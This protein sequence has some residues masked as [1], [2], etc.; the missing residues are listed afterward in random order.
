MSFSKRGSTARAAV[1]GLGLTLVAPAIGAAEDESTEEAPT[2]QVAAAESA[3]EGPVY[4]PPARERPRRRIGGGVRGPE[5]QWPHVYALVPTHT[6]HTSA[7][8]PSLFW[9]IDGQPPANAQ[10]G[11]YLINDA[12]NETVLATQLT[13]PDRAGIYRVRLTEHQVE[14]KPGVEYEWSVALEDDGDQVLVATGW[15]ERV[16][17]NG[18][19]PSGVGHDAVEFYAQRGLWYDALAALSDLIEAEPGDRD[20]KLARADL[21]AQVGLEAQKA[22]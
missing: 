17:L 5:Q 10:I 21:L 4:V 19:P 6:G 7:D 11:F 22:R 8:A 13:R 3:D 1:A 20:L 2:Q 15:V 14:L 12:T 18:S 9:S 16:P